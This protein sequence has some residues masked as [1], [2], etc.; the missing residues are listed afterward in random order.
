MI[1]DVDTVGFVYVRPDPVYETGV[2]RPRVE[3]D[4]VS[5]QIVPGFHGLDRR[6]SVT[7]T[8]RCGAWFRSF[9]R[10]GLFAAHGRWW[11]RRT[12]RTLRCA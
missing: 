3:I 4:D 12:R 8:R 9:T 6:L 5:L 7:P 2:D 1:D 10:R 11:L